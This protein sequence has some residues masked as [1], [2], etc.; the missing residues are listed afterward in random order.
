MAVARPQSVLTPLTPAAIFL[1][2][3]IDDGGETTVHDAL[4]SLS[5]SVRSVGFRVPAAK[6]NLV[7]GIGSAA[8]DRLFDAV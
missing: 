1:V 5:A 4:G 7:T 6:L 8:W 3:T 2:V